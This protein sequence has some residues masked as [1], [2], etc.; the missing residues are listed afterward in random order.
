MGHRSRDC[1]NK[2]TVKVA[3]QRNVSCYSKQMDAVYLEATL[4]SK[5]ESCIVDTGC[6]LSL[7]LERLAST[8][9]KLSAP[10]QLLAANGTSME[11]TGSVTLDLRLN[12]YP[13]T[14]TF[15]VSPDVDEIMLGM[16]FL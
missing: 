8:G 12:G 15:L 11:V 2:A 13:V 1:P 4:N 5:D 10:Q 6:Q 7:L 9:P 3:R 14:I 16:D